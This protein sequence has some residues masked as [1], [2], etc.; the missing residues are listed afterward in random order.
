VFSFQLGKI[1]VFF[2]LSGKKLKDGKKSVA[3]SFIGTTAVAE[4]SE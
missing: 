2:S 4:V 1:R 3:E